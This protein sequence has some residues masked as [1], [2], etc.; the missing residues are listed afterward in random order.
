[1]L[2]LLMMMR[3]GY[4]L[5]KTSWTGFI[6]AYAIYVHTATKTGWTNFTVYVKSAHLI[7][8]N[9]IKLKNNENINEIHIN[10]S[11]SHQHY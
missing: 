3:A 8:K 5:H 10:L 7:Q 9:A 11:P 4:T 2:L 6:F 1:M